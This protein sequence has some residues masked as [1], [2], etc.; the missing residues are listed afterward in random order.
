MAKVTEAGDAGAGHSPK[1]GRHADA[2]RARAARA[3]G[4]SGPDLPGPA[5][6]AG[7]LPEGPVNEL[8]RIHELNRQ[9]ILEDLVQKAKAHPERKMHPELRRE[10]KEIMNGLR[11][12]EFLLEAEVEKFRDGTYSTERPDEYALAAD[13]VRFAMYLL[14]K[15]REMYAVTLSRDSNSLLEIFLL[16][17]RGIK[18]MLS[19]DYF[20]KNGWELMAPFNFGYLD[21]RVEPPFAACAQAC[22]VELI[23][24]NPKIYLEE[25]LKRIG[26]K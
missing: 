6:G 24:L 12:F 16:A 9:N 26:A 11:L 5:A 14:D 18:E 19:P 13:R 2:M 17:A 1:E 10:A 15:I 7:P 8:Q 20:E 25:F 4:S 3:K 22:G 23:P 21:L